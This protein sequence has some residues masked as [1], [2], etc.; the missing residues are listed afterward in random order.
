M[1]AAEGGRASYPAIPMAPIRRS[2]CASDGRVYRTE[3]VA[4]LLLPMPWYAN[5]RVRVRGTSASVGGPE[6][7]RSGETTVPCHRAGATGCDKEVANAM[8]LTG[9]RSVLLS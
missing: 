7:E 5:S 1:G 2:R 6:K 9:K 4:S 8:P 3:V